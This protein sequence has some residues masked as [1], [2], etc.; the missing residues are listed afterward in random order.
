MADRLKL[1]VFGAAGDTGDQIVRQALQR[2]HDVRAVERAWDAP[3]PWAASVELAE[4]DV[5]SADL[6]EAVADRDAV[7]SAIGLA[8]SPMTVVAPPPL[9]TEGVLRTIRAMQGAG[10]RRLAVVSASFVA[11]RDR[12]PLWFRAAAQTALD[13]VFTQMGEMERILR[14]AD[15]IDWTAARP[16]WLLDAPLTQDYTVTPDVIPPNMIRTRHADLAHFLLD[17]VE[18]GDWIGGTPA[19]ARSEPASASTPDKLIRAALRR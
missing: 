14:A 12:G 1:A 15:R 17:C 16:G 10:V 11:S 18:T 9:Y 2:G 13:R 8:P 19:I 4:A 6:A 5:L 3:P 7:I